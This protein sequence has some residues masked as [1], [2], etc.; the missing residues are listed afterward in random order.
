MFLSLKTDICLEE[1]CGVDTGETILF[2]D[3][4]R[5]SDELCEK[6][7]KVSEWKPILS[8]DLLEKRFKKILP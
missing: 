3:S 4:N 6:D 7:G 5:L 1:V 8:P 2:C